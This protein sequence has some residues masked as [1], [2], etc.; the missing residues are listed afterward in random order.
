MSEFSARRRFLVAAAS[1]A[2]G[3]CSKH[4]CTN[5]SAELPEADTS[6]ITLHELTF[7]KSRG[8]PQKAVV[9]VPRWGSP[10]TRFPLLVALHGRG[11]ANRGLDV[12]AWGWVRDY[13]LDRTVARL[14]SPPL[15]H[16]DL[17]GLATPDYLGELNDSLAR[18]PFRGVV[19]ACP[20]TPDIL[21]TDDLDAA[22][23]FASFVVDYLIP[24]VRRR[25]PVIAKREATGIDGVSLGGRMAL[26]ASIERPDG[27]GVVGTLQAAFR[28]G[29]V[30]AVAARAQQAFGEGPSPRLVRL[31]TSTDDP[32]RSTLHK[33][34]VAMGGAG[35][36]VRYDVVPGPHDYDFNRGPGGYDM[37]CWHDRTLRGDGIDAG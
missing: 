29:E 7:E 8:G 13:G 16:A 6:Q 30:G 2:L 1:A 10:D 9:L 27:F 37:L 3:G 14:R 28:I 11:E 15:L 19:V 21:G 36:P 33:L 32:F 26:L 18:A 22:A 23:P 34:A 20:H 24:E 31:L 35:L 12:G 17:L 4:G 5:A 25:F